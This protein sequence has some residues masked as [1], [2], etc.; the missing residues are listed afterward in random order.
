MK[1]INY[2]IIVFISSIIVMVGFGT[3]DEAAAQS[4]IRSDLY[5]IN[6]QP[7]YTDNQGR[8]L[9]DYSYA[10]YMRGEQPIP[11]NPGSLYVN[12]TQ[13]PYN[14]DPT[15]SVETSRAIQSAIDFVGQNGGGVVYLPPGTYKV[16]PLPGNFDYGDS[17]HQHSALSVPYSNVMLRGAGPDQTFIYNDTYDMREK[18]IVQFSPRPELRFW[19]N[20]PEID[21]TR[22]SRDLSGP[23]NIL[24]VQNASKFNVND[25]VLVRT[26]LTGEFKAEHKMQGLWT[27]AFG[28]MYVRRV[29]DV[30]YGANTLTI[31]IPTRYYMKTRDNARV[32]KFQFPFIFNSGI[33]NLSIGMKNHPQSY[34]SSEGARD[35]HQS[36]AIMFNY[37]A[38]GWVS[39]VHSYK[40]PSNT[41][42]THI[43]S[44]A[45][46]I[47]HARS[48][49]VENS[50]F[51]NPQHVGVNGNGYLMRVDGG[52]S[53]MKNVTTGN[54]RHNFNFQEM[55]T[56]GNVL[57]NSTTYGSHNGYD[58]TD[59]HRNL[60]HANLIDGLTLHNDK[61]ESFNRTTYSNNA[62]FT[63]TQNVFWNIKHG[64][65]FCGIRSDQFGWGYIIGLDSA[66]ELR[67]EDSD[68]TRDYTEAIGQNHLLEPQSLYLD[69]LNRRL[70]RAAAQVPANVQATVNDDGKPVITWNNDVNSL[71]YQ[72]W[73]G[74][75]G[76]Y[77]TF[78]NTWFERNSQICSG[79]VCRLTVNNTARNGDYV[80]YLQS[81][82]AT[83]FNGGNGN[84]WSNP[85]YF[86]VSVPVPVVPQI[87]SVNTSN[88]V[89]VITW[90][91]DTN[92]KWYQFWMGSAGDY[93][94]VASYWFEKTPE[95][96]NGS[97][98]TTTLK[99]F[100]PQ[101]GDYVMYMQAWGGGGFND[102]NQDAWS[103]EAAFTVQ[104]GVPG[105]ISPRGVRETET[106]NPRFE[107]GAAENATWYNIWVGTQGDHQ[108]HYYGW[109][110]SIDMDCSDGS[111]CN[112]IMPDAMD[113][114]DYVWYVRTWGPG[115]MSERGTEGWAEAGTFGIR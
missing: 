88:G 94:T 20:E 40:P 23:T 102:N 109:V 1:S 110:S 104:L 5:P 72:I 41:K 8:Y 74:T 22:I 67:L 38:D 103:S 83:G 91:N 43:L 97:T 9:Q 12:V 33:E 70:N 98:C 11:D 48:I 113:A 3:Q 35:M 19:R 24:P 101:N 100:F 37:I 85:A 56:T 54:G 64:G 92:A 95:M 28:T 73:I 10:G 114:G 53:L 99:A 59:F 47:Y 21:V 14:A 79:D 45:V 90:N 55:H 34:T 80:V 49:Q 31:D 36:S 7:G 26:D 2:L 63:A 17:F 46:W 44:T 60:T 84:L 6:W 112:F 32:H 69:Q 58:H 52:D 75:D 30:D 50:S 68:S 86:S 15:G 96:C 42:D 78:H 89:P 51:F 111:D 62:G 65:G 57:L 29:I 76:D 81:W 82:G 39:N 106:A 115:G 4:T 66:C 13:A 16:R 27:E 71:W 25:W 108:T 87:I 61:I 93:E 105:L 107:F 18:Y 77:E